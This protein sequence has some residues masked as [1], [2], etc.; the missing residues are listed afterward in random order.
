MAFEE[1][2]FADFRWAE[3]TLSLS[4]RHNPFWGRLHEQTA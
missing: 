4:E 2:G 1:A 3:L